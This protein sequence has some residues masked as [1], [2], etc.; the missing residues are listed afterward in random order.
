MSQ[1]RY[2]RQQRFC[3]I[4][5]EGQAKIDSGRIAVVGMGALGTASAMLLARAGVGFLRLIDRDEVEYS[6]LTRQVLYDE[7]DAREHR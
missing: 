5:K 7:E 2:A 3:G 1:D 4:G 6:N